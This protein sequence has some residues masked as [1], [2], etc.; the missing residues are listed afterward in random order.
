M[1][2]LIFPKDAH[3]RLSERLCNFEIIDFSNMPTLTFEMWEFQMIN[4]FLECPI[5]VLR[6]GNFESTEYRRR[7]DHFSLPLQ[8]KTQLSYRGR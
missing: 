6:H 2:L 8:P 3:I 4:I 7:S 1:R 5:E